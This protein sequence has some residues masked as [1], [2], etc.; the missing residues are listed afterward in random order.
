MPLSLNAP[1]FPDPETTSDLVTSA[2]GGGLD[3]SGYLWTCGLLVLGIA[4]IGWGLRRILAG[5]VAA[6][7]AKRSLRVVDV[8]PL[9][10]RKKLAVVSCYDRTFLLGLGDKEVGVVA[11]LDTDGGEYLPTPGTEVGAAEGSATAER[12]FTELFDRVDAA[13]ARRSSSGLGSGQGVLG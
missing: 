3:L 2:A 12:D 9:G 8:L 5:T 4:G 1:S 13:R 6:R 11:E 7:A 10:G